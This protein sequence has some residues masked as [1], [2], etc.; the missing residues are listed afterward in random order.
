MRNVDGENRELIW[1]E[2]VEQQKGSGLSVAAYCRRERIS[3]ASYYYWKRRL[4]ERK[5]KPKTE[6]GEG[7]G[8]FVAIDLPQTVCD[9]LEVVLRNGRRLVVPDRFSENTLRALLAILE[10]S[11][12]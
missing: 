11:A 3:E 9:N 10:D 5:D 2:K 6:S 12:C 7:D 8:R 1:R 4:A